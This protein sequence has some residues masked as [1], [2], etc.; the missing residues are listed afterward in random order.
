[1][2]AAIQKNNKF[3]DEAE[4]TYENQEDL[5][6]DK[7]EQQEGMEVF[8]T[9]WESCRYPNNAIQCT[10]CCSETHTNLEIVVI[11]RSHQISILPW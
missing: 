7:E 5:S 8:L 9:N 11:Y 10:E 3:P 6:D 2:E 1:M 4:P